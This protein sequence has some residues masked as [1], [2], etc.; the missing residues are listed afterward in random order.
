[1]LL[2]L[3]KIRSF[4]IY[5]INIQARNYK[6]G[7][8]VDFSVAIIISYYLF[9]IKSAWRKKNYQ[10]NN[11]RSFDYILDE[12]RIVTLNRATSNRECLSKLRSRDN[13]NRIIKQTSIRRHKTIEKEIESLTKN[14][15]IVTTFR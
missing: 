5:N 7:R 1:M 2:D 11:L 12:T 9:V 14:R 10:Y 13:K 3:R 4:E 8:L 6:D 15:R